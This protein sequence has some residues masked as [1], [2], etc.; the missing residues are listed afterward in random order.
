MSKRYTKTE[1]DF[2]RQ[3]FNDLTCRELGQKIGRTKSSV[4]NRLKYLH[5]HR[6]P[7]ARHRMMTLSQFP[8]GHRPFNFG[9][10]GIHLSRATEFQKGHQ[11]AIT[12]HDGYIATRYCHGT[13]YKYIRL[14]K[15]K[16]IL[17][18]HFIWEKYHGLIPPKH[19]IG[20][21]DGNSLNCNLENLY[22]MSKA[23]NC[24]RN[25]NMEKVRVSMLRAWEQG[26]HLQSDKYIAN[27]IA[28]TDPA[29]KE[30]IKTC[31][32]L[33]ALKRLQFQ[34]RR[35]LHAKKP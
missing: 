27:L 22:L 12:K 2:I 21:K 14:A 20:F 24:R 10:K 11:P 29:L 4:R 31:A 5:L 1:D 8:K 32:E 15:N 33:L 7:E 34:L 28:P 35:Q 25:Y 18:H 6:S 13:A 19:I 16:W 23:D 17:Y 9:R 26:K 3:N 30:K